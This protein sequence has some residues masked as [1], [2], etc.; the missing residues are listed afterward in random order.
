MSV[1]DKL[2]I[3]TAQQQNTFDL[4]GGKQVTISRTKNDDLLQSFATS[5][6]LSSRFVARAAESDILRTLLFLGGDKVPQLDGNFPIAQIFPI[7]LNHSYDFQTMLSG[8]Y[9]PKVEEASKQRDDSRKSLLDAQQSYSFEMLSS[10]FSNPDTVRAFT[11]NRLA[12]D[13]KKA[14]E[15][16]FQM[17]KEENLKRIVAFF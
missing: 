7:V 8:P 15:Q 9:K 5:D 12:E 2:T 10:V 4:T 14:L 3:F 11:R 6:S 1:W 13:R 16:A 17:D